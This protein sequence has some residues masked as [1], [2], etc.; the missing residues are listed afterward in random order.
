MDN[1]M[2]TGLAFVNFRKAFNVINRELLLKKLFIY[3]ASDLSFKWC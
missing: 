1:D 2:V 3:G